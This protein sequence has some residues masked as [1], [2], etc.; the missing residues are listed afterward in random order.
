MIDANTAK[1]G[2]EALGTAI[3]EIME[4]TIDMALR[5]QAEPRAV[6]T[7]LLISAGQD[8]EALGRAMAVLEQRGRAD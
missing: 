5:G 1:A 6:Q 4:D 3:G 8:I 7:D 2:V